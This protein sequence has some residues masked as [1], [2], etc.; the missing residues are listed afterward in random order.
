M[1]SSYLLGFDFGG[2]GGRCALVNV[3]TAEI[4]TAFR[5]WRHPALDILASMVGL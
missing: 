3:Q 4:S 5:P 2:G 1:T